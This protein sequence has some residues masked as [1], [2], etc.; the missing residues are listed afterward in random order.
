MKGVVRISAEQGVKKHHI[1]IMNHIIALSSLE[2]MWSMC[3]QHTTVL[4]LT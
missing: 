4:L 1:I 3:D 2:M